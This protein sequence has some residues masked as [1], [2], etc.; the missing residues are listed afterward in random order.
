MSAWRDE[1]V[2]FQM[3]AVSNPLPAPVEVED[4]RWPVHRRK[5]LDWLINDTRSERYIDKILV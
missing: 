1:I 4:G 2:E 5:I 3:Q